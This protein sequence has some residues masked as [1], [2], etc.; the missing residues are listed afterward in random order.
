MQIDELDEAGFDSG[1]FSEPERAVIRF[2]YESTR[3]VKASDEA[4]ADLKTHFSNQAIAEITFVVASGNFIQRVGKTSALNWKAESRGRV[5]TCEGT[6]VSR[7]SGLASSGGC[8][9]KCA[10]F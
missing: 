1:E 2:A 3:D 9:H 10:G 5:I 4:M 6:Q 8:R 7:V